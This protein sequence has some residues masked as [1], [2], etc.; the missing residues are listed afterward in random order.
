MSKVIVVLADGET[1]T[2][3]TGCSICIVSDESFDELVAGAD[4]ND[5]DHELEIELKTYENVQGLG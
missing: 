4:A 3:A 5:V 2:E 1:W